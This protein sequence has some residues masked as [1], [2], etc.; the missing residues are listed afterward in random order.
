MLKRIFLLVIVSTLL[1][2]SLTKSFR[3]KS[4]P[5]SQPIK[6]STISRANIP[7]SKIKAST[8]IPRRLTKEEKVEAY[9][10]D[11]AAIAQEEMK[12]YKI[13]ASITL[14]QGI[15]ESGAGY[16]RLAREGN[17]HFGI[18]CH[19]GWNGG[20][21]YHDD[22][23][24][25][26]CFR[27]YKNSKESYRDHSIFLSGRQRYA[28]LFDMHRRDYK[29]WARG[30][31]K[32]GY[33]TDPKYPQKLIAVIEQYKLYRFDSKKGKYIK[34]VDVPV[35][36]TKPRITTPKGKKSVYRVDKGDTLYS[37]SRKYRIS[38]EQLK[39]ENN[40]DSNTIYIGQELII[41]KL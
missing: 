23:A 26:E 32:A 3:S 11:F 10:N 37:I 29:A 15:V 8:K 21:I 5:K 28:F 34:V 35:K 18:K 12:R 7:T 38:V 24:K 1:G 22:D 17:N 9:I 13:P 2:C 31:K 30:L 14:A 16:S 33:A 39:K 41:P 25:D 36:K 4:R 6:K 19:R 40:L 20:K 27:V